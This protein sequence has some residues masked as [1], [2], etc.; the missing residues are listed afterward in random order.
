MKDHE[1]FMAAAQALYASHTAKLDMSILLGV[2]LRTVRRWASGE[3][4]IPSGVWDE[5]LTELCRKRDGA[6]RVVDEVSKLV[7]DR[8]TQ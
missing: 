4:E 8:A 6:Q 3:E 5:V 1:I 2:G 7:I